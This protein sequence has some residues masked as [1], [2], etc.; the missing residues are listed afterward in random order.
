MKILLAA[1][2]DSCDIFDRVAKLP[3]LGIVSM[4]GNLPGHTVQV[5]DLVLARPHVRRALLAALRTHQPQ[6]VGLSAMTFQ[7]DTLL[8]AARLVRDVDP[9]VR[10]VVGGYHA[11][12]MAEHVTDCTAQPPFDFVVR[13][14]GELTLRAL[15]DALDAG[16]GAVDL[17]SIP[18]LSYRTDAGWVHNSERPLADLAALGLPDR[19]A[20]LAS[21]FYFLGVPFDVVETSRGCPAACK[22]CS[23]TR[24]YGRTFRPFPIARVVADLR[25]VRARGAHAVFFVDDNITCD[26]AHFRRLCQAI[27]DEGLVNMQY[28]VQVTAAGIANNPDLA[29]AMAAAN[30]RYAFVGFESMRTTGLQQMQKPTSPEINRR[31]ARL[32]R[33]HGIALIGGLIAGYPDD[34]RET[35]REDFRLFRE[36]RADMLYGQY[37]TPYPKTVLRD[38]LLA[39]DLITNIDDFRTYDGFNCNVRTRHL[40]RDALHRAFKWEAMKFALQPSHLLRNRVLHRHAGALIKSLGYTLLSDA[41]N[42]ITAR[43]LRRS[44]DL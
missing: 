25:Q 7:W 31:A 28:M 41:F 29:P 18:G 5:I 4:A 38:E 1:M 33:Q 37:L 26:T 17:A 9:A 30:F 8:R 16:P 11:S 23:I 43:G 27:V 2:P 44:F 34:T 6:L 14:E 12:L 13:G 40:T 32:L 21:R 22:F 35:L 42:V 20:R 3:N 39:A 24:M 36:L 19:G 10:I 15:A